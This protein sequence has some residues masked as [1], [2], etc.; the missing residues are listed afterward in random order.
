MAMGM[1]RTT[2]RMMYLV[3]VSTGQGLGGDYKFLQVRYFC[4]DEIRFVREA[5]HDPSQS[6]FSFF[7]I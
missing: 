4:V 2:T 7:V 3:S 6:F 5:G 1:G